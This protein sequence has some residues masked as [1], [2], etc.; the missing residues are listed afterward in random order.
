MP[1]Q[2]FRLW[3]TLH[4]SSREVPYQ[5][6]PS[7][8][9]GSLQLSRQRSAVTFANT[10]HSGRRSRSGK[11]ISRPT[12]RGCRD[13]HVPV[14][15][16]SACGAS[17]LSTSPHW[18]F[19]D[20]LSHRTWRAFWT[21]SRPSSDKTDSGT[22]PSLSEKVRWRKI[23]CLLCFGWLLLLASILS[24]LVDDRHWLACFQAL[25]LRYPE[26]HF[27]AIRD[28]CVFCCR[29]PFS[30][31]CSRRMRKC[32]C[33]SRPPGDRDIGALTIWGRHGVHA[34]TWHASAIIRRCPPDLFWD[35]PLSSTIGA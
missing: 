11:K 23:F 33:N 12:C 8:N 27:P 32:Y 24:F 35:T 21:T 30:S 10:R 26:P 7:A 25:R 4:A 13:R 16:G 14:K 5:T 28:P 2:E 15:L 17:I 1:I 22:R 34:I 18:K 29:W 6:F 31:F 3:R 19:R 9:P 20:H